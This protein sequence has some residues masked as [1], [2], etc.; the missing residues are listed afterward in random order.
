MKLPAPLAFD[1][2]KG[3]IDKNWEKHRVFYR[4]AEEVFFNQPL[5]IF[6]D[7]K[8]SGTEKRYQALGVANNGRTLSI[9]FTIRNKKIRV[10]SARDQ[11]KK[12]KQRYG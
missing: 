9:F 4:E 3:N 11:N 2:D 6:S 12:E 7:K 1:W 5:L 8:H 10:I